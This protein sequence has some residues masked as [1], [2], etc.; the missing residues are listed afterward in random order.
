MGLLGFVDVVQG[1]E[2][3]K[4]NQCSRDARLWLLGPLEPEPQEQ[5]MGMALSDQW[6]FSR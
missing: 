5:V 1:E 3:L 6:G 2:D 4:T